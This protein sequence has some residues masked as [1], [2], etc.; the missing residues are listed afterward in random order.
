[1]NKIIKVSRLSTPK[2]IKRSIKRIV[3]QLEKNNYAF[4]SD[5]KAVRLFSR[6]VKPYKDK[7]KIIISSSTDKKIKNVIS[8][9]HDFKL[10]RC[11][12][13]GFRL[14]LKD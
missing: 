1:M 7:G 6:F 2:D 5:V 8:I 11:G 3:D 10:V 12:V 14:K 4:S 13:F 9:K